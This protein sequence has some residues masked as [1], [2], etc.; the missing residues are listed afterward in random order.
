MHILWPTGG[1]TATPTES[2]PPT[3]RRQSN[4]LQSLRKSSSAP[5]ITSS[6]WRRIR[7]VMVRI[8]RAGCRINPRSQRWAS[9]RDRQLSGGSCVEP[10]GYQLAT[11]KSTYF[12]RKTP[13]VFD[14]DVYRKSTG[15]LASGKS[16]GKSRSWADATEL[17]SS[18][19][20]LNNRD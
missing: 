18:D 4:I 20:K 16:S 11:S 7:M 8:I 10:E 2:R 5:T 17:S 9:R 15:G 12:C 1:S 13:D 14:V 3:C 19:T 6:I